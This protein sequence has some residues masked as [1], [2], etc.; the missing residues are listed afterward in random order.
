MNDTQMIRFTVDVRVKADDALTVD[1]I[2]NELDVCPWRFARD[3]GVIH[4][5]F[6]K[7]EVVDSR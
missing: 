4:F 7:G 6:I 2:M 3:V 5:D 1:Q